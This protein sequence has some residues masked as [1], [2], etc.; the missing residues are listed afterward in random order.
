MSPLGDADP[1]VIIT[2]GLLILVAV[3]LIVMKG[4]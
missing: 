4:D 1:A 3:V 2:F